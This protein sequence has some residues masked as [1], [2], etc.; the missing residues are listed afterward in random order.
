MF[1]SAISLPLESQYDS[2]KMDPKMQTV[3]QMKADVQSN[4]LIEF[5]FKISFEK[6]EKLDVEKPFFKGGEIILPVLKG[7]IC[8]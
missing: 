6:F 5:F 1:F 4:L 3:Y 2:A 8:S 7:L